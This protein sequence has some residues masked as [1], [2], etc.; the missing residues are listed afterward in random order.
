M[1]LFSGKVFVSPIFTLGVEGW[2]QYLFSPIPNF[3][4]FIAL[5]YLLE[6]GTNDY[7]FIAIGFIYHFVLLGVLLPF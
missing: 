4:T 5:E 7:L 2:L 1:H 6:N 3:W